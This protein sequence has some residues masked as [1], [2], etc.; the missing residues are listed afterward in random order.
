MAKE[1]HAL[2]ATDESS[3]SL[4]PAKKR[5][6]VPVPPDSKKRLGKNGGVYFNYHRNGRLI[7]HAVLPKIVKS[8]VRRSFPAMFTNI[9]NA[10]DAEL[11]KK[12]LDTYYLPEFA[13]KQKF[14]RKLQRHRTFIAR[15]LDSVAS[16]TLS[17]AILY[18]Y[19]RI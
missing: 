11:M 16:L 18:C 1:D 17:R 8:D 19:L 10:C 3:L 12:Y 9:Y 7:V 2:L 6:R 13:L 5:I 15:A 4:S 14:S